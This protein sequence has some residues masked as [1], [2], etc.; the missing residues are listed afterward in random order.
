MLK[1]LGGLLFLATLL[2]ATYLAG[3]TKGASHLYAENAAGE[4]FLLVGTLRKVRS[5]ES[6]K[7]I[8]DL[9]MALN[10][11]VIESSWRDE[12]LGVF[13]GWFGLASNNRQESLSAVAE[14]RADFPCSY[15]TADVCA[16]AAHVLSSQHGE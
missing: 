14:Y 11:R 1:I 13:F 3:A 2:L 15:P 7:V 8:E 4:A 16:K 5:E 10:R 6:E 12:W 9:E